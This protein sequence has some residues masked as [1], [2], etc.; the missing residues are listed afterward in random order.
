[1]GAIYPEP[2]W[3]IMGLSKSGCKYLHWGT[4][5]FKYGY[6]FDSLVAKRPEPLS[7]P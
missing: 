7:N 3:R 5:E 4:T 6:P 1:M 2:T